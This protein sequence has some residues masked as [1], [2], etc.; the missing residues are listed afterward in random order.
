MVGYKI[1]LGNLLTAAVLVLGFTVIAIQYSVLGDR[2]SAIETRM[3]EANKTTVA[4]LRS[5][6]R[7]I[8]QCSPTSEALPP[9]AAGAVR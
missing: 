1:D 9:I 5:L 7:A 3:M 2:L 6:D 8:A 4:V